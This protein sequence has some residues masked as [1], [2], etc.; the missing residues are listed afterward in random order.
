[1]I[2]KSIND[3]QHQ[4]IYDILK[5]HNNSESIELDP[6]YSKGVF[7][8]NSK[9]L[10]EEPKYKF[11]LIPQTEDTIQAS[12]DNI[13]LESDSIKSIMFDP[14][15]VISGKTWKD[16]EDESCK[17]TKRFGCY[18]SWD[19]LKDHYSK[20]IIEFNRLLKPNGILIFKLQNTISSAKQ[21]FSHY[22]VMKEAINFGFYPI[23]EFVLTAKSK[24]TSFGGRWKTQ[25][26]AMKYHS[27]FL[28]FRKTP[29]KIDYSSNI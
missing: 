1:M 4:I 13:P 24:M 8:K 9:G 7:Y 26:N 16:S 11:D 29:C 14:P 12:S 23:D 27:Y 5:L 6:T 2:I 20:S 10:I 22:Y 15:F 18:Y 17:I 28:V 19:E 21:Y 3:N 25:R